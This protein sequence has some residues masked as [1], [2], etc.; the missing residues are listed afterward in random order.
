M[1]MI[2]RRG[3]LKTVGLASAG[4]FVSKIPDGRAEAAEARSGRPNVVLIMTDDQGWGQTGYY[5]H[6]ALKTPNIDK[7]AANGLRFDRFYAGAPVCSPTR[8]SVLTGRANDRTGV[9]SHG[10]ALRLQEKTLPAAMKAAGY[11]TGHFGKWHLNGFRGPGVPVLKDDT[12]SPGAFG[13][14]EWLTVTNFFDMN[15]IMSRKGSFEEFKGD[16]SAIIVAEA[17]KFISASTKKNKPFLAVIW[18]GSPHSPWRAS[19]S[20]RKPF[21]GLNT[22]SQHHYGE[23]AA[24]DRS[25]GVL[26]KGLR[27]LGIADN[28]L[29]WYCS[30]NGGLG[31]IE[32]DTVGGLRGYKGSVYEGGLR[33][34]GIIEWPA[35]IK[36][37]ITN[38]PASTMDIFPT[39]AHILGLDDSVLLKPTDGV[40]LTPMFKQKIAER[41]KPIPFRF[42]R[43]GALVDNDYKLV[44]MDIRKGTFALYNLKTDPKESKDISKDQP[45]IFNTMKSAFQKWNATVDASVAGKD[46]P[47]GK[48]RAD[49]PQPRF[50][51]AD[52]RYK[53]YFE[54]WKKRPE[55]AGRLKPRA[56][57]KPRKKR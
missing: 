25:V 46:Y 12:H 38:H 1:A 44:A 26:R 35:G 28:T 2:D 8:A 15:P 31:G 19:E 13:F 5:N 6:P 11:S 50:W 52:Q 16:S 3:F 10:H 40:S 45:G 43:K 14:D 37:R 9:P 30:D 34:P 51:T 24:F 33:V 39:I 53:P 23:L 55:Y 27:D 36:P 48:V 4:L 42:G 7:M 49:H 47:E 17:M 22:R 32:P 18:D 41:K 57:K 21:A 56:R 29:V 20:D 54:D